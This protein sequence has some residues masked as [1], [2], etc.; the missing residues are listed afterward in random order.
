VRRLTGSSQEVDVEALLAGL[1]LGGRATD[2]RP[3]TIANFASSIDGHA[4]IDGRSGG[5]GDEG[6]R[7]IFHALRGMADAVIVG[8]GTLRAERYGRMIADP[9]R[10][11]RR[12]LRGLA[13]EPIACT[14]TRSGVVDAG[15]P[16]FATPE[17][18]VVIFSG[19][20]VELGEPAAT[21]E[22]VR[23]DPG[24][25]TLTT[26]L[27]RLRT[28][29]DVRL[30]LCEGGPGLFGGLLRE[31]LVDEL[32]VTLAPKLVA[33]EGPRITAGTPLPQAA[34]LHLESVLERED[35]LFLG[36]SIRN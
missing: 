14:V 35:F 9:D 36:Y 15:I 8:T 30:L 2:R 18:T 17:A 25:L 4:T 32:F 13:P 3:Y 33:G 19:A 12:E 5:L 26:V 16:L 6:D 24:L 28:D 31:R 29:H 10:R 7:E 23:I 34:A 1:E 22:V 21:V 27:E 20:P 11:R